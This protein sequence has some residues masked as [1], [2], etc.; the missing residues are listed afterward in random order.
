MELLEKLKNLNLD[1]IEEMT[2]K[3]EREEDRKFY[4]DLYNKVLE[5]RHK[6]SI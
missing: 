4:V 6:D 1:E 3:S 2:V 5:L